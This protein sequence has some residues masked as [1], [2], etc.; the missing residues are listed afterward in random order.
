METK[1][2]NFVRENATKNLLEKY[3][4]NNLIT[5]NLSISILKMLQENGILSDEDYASAT[6]IVASNHGLNNTSIFVSN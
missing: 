2:V 1:D 4:S 5:Y 6:A 3:K